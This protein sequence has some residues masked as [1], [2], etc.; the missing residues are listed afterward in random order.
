MPKV[1]VGNF[2]ISL[3]GYGSGPDQSLDEG[4]GVGGERL[5]EWMVKTRTWRSQ[6]GMDGGE[7]GIDDDFAA[8]GFEGIGATI[9]GRNMFGPIRGPWGDE[10]WSGWWGDDPPYHHSTYVLTHYARPSLPMQGG[11]V[12]HFV[13]DGIEAALEQARQTAGGKDILIAGGAGT[14][15]QFLRARLLDE[16]RVAIAPIFLGGGERL[17]DDLGGATDDYE[18]VELVSSPA[19]VHVRLERR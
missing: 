1:R 9:M 4:L 3:D 2:T 6:Q 19:A 14:I 18:C 5:H 16:L 12:F 13:T 17:F 7:T 10:E 11:T 15:R 8:R